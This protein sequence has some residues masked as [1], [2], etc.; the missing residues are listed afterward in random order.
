MHAHGGPA[1][2]GPAKQ[3][4]AEEDLKRWAVTVRA[5][6]AWA[7]STYRRGGYGVTMAAEDTERL[8]Q[9]FVRDF[10]QPRRTLLHG[11]SYGAGVAAKG[12]ELYSAPAGARGPYDGVL[13]TSGVLGGGGVA[14]DFRLDLR[15]VY[16][17]VCNNHPRPD[18]A[19][20]PLWQGLPPDSKLTRAELA[21]RVDD[22]TG[23]R[24]PATQR[25]EQQKAR[26]ATIVNVVKI[27]EPSLV[28]HLTQGTWLFRDLVQLRLGGRNPFDNSSVRYQG[29]PGDAAL[30]ARVLRYT[31]DP[32]AVA[33]LAQDSAPTGKVGMPVLTFHAANDPTAFVELESVYREVFERAGTA[34][35]LV[36][37]FSDESEH[38]Y[39]GEPQYPALFKAL[40]EW[41]D[42]GTRPTPH[43]VLAL[44]RDYEASYAKGCRIQPDWRSPP[45][46]TRVA[47]RRP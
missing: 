33:Q 47:P 36:Q 6:H 40:L 11:Q 2:T 17:F 7:G 38:S 25:S 12:A 20:Y 23:V 16:Q 13:L 4:R 27:P 10:G 22:C 34:S 39:L 21:A 30:N 14:Y 41:I 28:S 35:R 19:A 37:V 42:Q 1:E 45:L 29:S 44:C 43:R 8:R 9:I 18:E 32:Q 24:K 31:A 26:L 3:E 5:G 15:V 46:H